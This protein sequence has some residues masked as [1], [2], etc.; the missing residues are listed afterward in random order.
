LTDSRPIRVLLVDDDEEHYLISRDLLHDVESGPGFRLE[1]VARYEDALAAVKRA[2]HDVY[3]LDYRLGDRDGLE[4]LREARQ[5]GCGAPMIL[6]T[7]QGDREVDLQ[8]MAAGAT[9]YLV[10]GEIN[11]PLLERSIRYA[12]ERS[13]VEQLRQSLVAPPP[14]SFGGLLPRSKNRPF[15]SCSMTRAS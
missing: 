13:R 12:I 4:L 10:K 11:A 2:E 15:G 3:L 14:A 8:A 9:D 6:L 7:G 5:L 1:W